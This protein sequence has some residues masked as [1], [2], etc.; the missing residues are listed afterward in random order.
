METWPLRA[1]VKSELVKIVRFQWQHCASRS[2][3]TR[4]FLAHG[5]CM[6]ERCASDAHD[7]VFDSFEGAAACSG[8]L[9]LTNSTITASSP[10]SITV[11]PG[12]TPGFCHYTV[13]GNDGASTQTEGDGSLSANRRAQ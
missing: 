10:A 6:A 8:S 4:V 7:A 3:S 11:N 13:T 1:R 5:L 12:S 2:I 9:T